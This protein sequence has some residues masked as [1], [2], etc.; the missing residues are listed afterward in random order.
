MQQLPGKGPT[1]VVTQPIGDRVGHLTFHRVPDCGI[2]WFLKRILAERA[3]LW[4]TPQGAS[5]Q[6]A[7]MTPGPE[8]CVFR[9][10]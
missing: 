7:L 2:V 3:R 10:E 1:L 8:D 5:N 9:T 4:I 6:S